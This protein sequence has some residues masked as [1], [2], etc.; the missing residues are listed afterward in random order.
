MVALYAGSSSCSTTHWLTIWNLIG[1][2]KQVI[3]L[4]KRDTNYKGKDLGKPS[5]AHTSLAW[6]NQ[7]SLGL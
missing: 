3:V 6:Y 5:L 2:V 7:V 4:A 1:T